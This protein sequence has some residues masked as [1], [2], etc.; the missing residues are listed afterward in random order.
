MITPAALPDGVRSGLES[1]HIQIRLGAVAALGEWLADSDPA[2]ALAARQTLEQVAG[3]DVPKVAEA[4]QA[5]VGE[6]P[7]VGLGSIPD[8]DSSVAAPKEP[9]REPLPDGSAVGDTGSGPWARRRRPLIIVAALAALAVIGTLTAIMLWN[10]TT[11]NT[12]GQ[13]PSALTQRRRN[14]IAGE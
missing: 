7:E 5:L 6:P 3:S 14:A 11:P 2:R 12:Q 9:E 13:N 4:A 10:P 8:G 1:P